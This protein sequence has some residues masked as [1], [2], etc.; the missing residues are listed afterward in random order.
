MKIDILEDEEGVT[1]DQNQSELIDDDRDA[2]DELPLS[3]V[4]ILRKHLHEEI[5]TTY[6][7][8]PKNVPQETGP[9][10]LEGLET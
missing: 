1:V 5:D 6:C 2:E 4:R 9:V 8:V 7:T 10:L 3:D